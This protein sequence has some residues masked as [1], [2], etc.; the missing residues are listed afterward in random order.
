MAVTRILLA[1]VLTMIVY[2][3]ALLWG[4]FYM[5][6]YGLRAPA[7]VSLGYLKPVYRAAF[8]HLSQVV[9][10][11]SVWLLWPFGNW[12]LAALLATVWG[13]KAGMRCE[14]LRAFV[15][16][17]L[18]RLDDGLPLR[19]AWSG[20]ET[21]IVA[22]T[23]IRHLSVKRYAGSPTALI[24]YVV[25]TTRSSGEAREI[26]DRWFRWANALSNGDTATFGEQ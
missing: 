13:F 25:M 24:Q 4:R 15:R 12:G 5:N 16:Q 14:M 7:L 21:T 22:L 3:H 18:L 20:A 26:T 11:I 23:G 10:L 19:E 17:L 8:F 1:A 6:L 2:K 9:L